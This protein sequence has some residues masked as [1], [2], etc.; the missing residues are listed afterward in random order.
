MR[1]SFSSGSPRLIL[2]MMM[3]RMSLM[4]WI[5]VQDRMILTCWNWEKLGLSFAKLGM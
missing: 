5:P 2:M 4:M 1:R 3:R